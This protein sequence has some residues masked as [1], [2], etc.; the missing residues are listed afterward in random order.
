VKEFRVAPDEWECRVFIA[1]AENRGAEAAAQRLK[2]HRG[3]RYERQ[4]VE[5][6][7]KKI[8]AWV[9]EPLLSRDPDRKLYLTGRGQE[10]LESA[11][12]IV[13][14]YQLM[15][16]EI[17]ERALP[18]L[19]CLPHHTHFVAMAESLLFEQAPP[20]GT[21][22]IFVEYLPQ[23][24]RGEGEFHR[25]AVTQLRSN[26]YQLI[27]GPKVD[28]MTTFESKPLYY[29][30][31]EAMVSRQY[32]ADEM[33]LTDLVQRHQMLVPPI[34]MRSRRLLEDSIEKWGIDDPGLPVR[35]AAETYE[36]A[37]SVLRV[38]NE[39]HG[40]GEGDSRVVVVPSDAALVYKEGMEFGGRHAD[41]FKWVPIYHRDDRGTD[42]LLRMEVCVTIRRG[43]QSDLPGIV[44]ALARAVERLNDIPGQVGLCGAPFRG[45]RPSLIPV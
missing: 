33:S 29:A 40:R 36:T 21:P 8:E 34:D 2:A 18:K 42:H 11:H 15:R 14:Q 20:K 37:T 38:R 35:V 10:F 30:Q 43:G 16:G 41:R 7:L 39:Y 28:D 32:R 23:N 13:T 27:I 4:S 45:R 22:K 3:G 12:N 26:A 9:G 24:Y 17:P 31:L 1:V 44:A 6:I 25:L 19:A 5:K